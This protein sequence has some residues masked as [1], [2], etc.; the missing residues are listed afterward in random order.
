MK[1]FRIHNN[2]IFCVFAAV[3]LISVAAASSLGGAERLRHAGNFTRYKYADDL[4]DA[5]RYGEARDIYAGLIGEYPVSYAVV[6]KTALCEFY[7]DNYDDAITYGLKALEL[8]PILT[9]DEDFLTF[10]EISFAEVGD[11]VNAGIMAEKR[12]YVQQKKA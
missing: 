12:R 11:G 3:A 5:D 4:Y 10:M 6:Y 8:L 2:L 9:D 1:T 7:L